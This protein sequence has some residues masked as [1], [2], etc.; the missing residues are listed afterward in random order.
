MILKHTYAPMILVRLPDTGR[1]YCEYGYPD[2]RLVRDLFAYHPI[3][4]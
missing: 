1:H 3:V 4:A 2:E